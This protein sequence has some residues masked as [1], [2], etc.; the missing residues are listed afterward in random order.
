MKWT[1]WIVI[2][3]FSAV[4]V[5]Q[6]ALLQR[7]QLYGE[8]DDFRATSGNWIAIKYSTASSADRAI[9]SENGQLLNAGTLLSVMR[10]TPPLA[11]KLQ[12]FGASVDH[13]NPLDPY[14]ANTRADGYYE[15]HGGLDGRF[16]TLQHRHPNRLP[17]EPGPQF[18]RVPAQG[19]E[20]RR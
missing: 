6:A 7:F 4:E 5:T 19:P 8:I 10:L 12:V 18:T 20:A 1:N 9:V 11:D 15:Y 3:G 13:V 14:S 2:S 16:N 17:G